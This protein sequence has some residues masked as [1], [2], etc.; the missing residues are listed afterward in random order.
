M[1]G[2]RN[3][4]DMLP[5][6]ISFFLVIIIKYCRKCDD[7]TYGKVNE[8][9]YSDEAESRKKQEDNFVE[10]ENIYSAEGKDMMSQL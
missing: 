2:G 1:I 8:V 5:E 4:G 3:W 10:E 6:I 7:W 9:Q